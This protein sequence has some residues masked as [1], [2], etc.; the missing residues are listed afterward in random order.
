M[1][2]GNTLQSFST[3]VQWLAEQAGK[4]RAGVEVGDQEVEAREGVLE[5]FRAMADVLDRLDVADGEALARRFHSQRRRARVGDTLGVAALTDFWVELE[6]SDERI[7][8]LDAV[9][10]QIIA[11]SASIEQAPARRHMRDRAVPAEPPESAWVVLDAVELESEFKR[12]VPVLQSCPIFLR[13]RWQFVA[14]WA[15]S[16]RSAAVAQGDA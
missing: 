10:R 16:H 15:L 9:V 11:T 5:G 4:L 14:M 2:L 7:S 3:F 12:R 13:G 6:R 8:M 1:L